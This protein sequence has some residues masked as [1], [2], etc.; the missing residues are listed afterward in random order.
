MEDEEDNLEQIFKDID[1]FKNGKLTYILFIS[2]VIPYSKLFSEKRLIIFY[3]ICNFTAEQFIC[4][5]DLQ[6]FLKRQFKYSN[7]MN[8]EK[9]L[10][11]CEEFKVMFKG[12]EKITFDQFSRSINED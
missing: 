2:S 10:E 12:N 11:L 5:N 6:C 7:L 1:I 9:I 4:S 3:Q 8:D